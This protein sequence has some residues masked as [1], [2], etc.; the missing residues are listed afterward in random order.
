M[1]IIILTSVERLVIFICDINAA[2]TFR[3]QILLKQ[4][5]EATFKDIWEQGD[6]NFDVGARCCRENQYPLCMH[7]CTS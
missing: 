3:C 1:V 6:E 7:K 4:N 2:S 5:G